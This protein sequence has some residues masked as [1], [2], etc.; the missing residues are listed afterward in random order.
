ML[1]Q[2]NNQ[3]DDREK[4]LFPLNFFVKSFCRVFELPLLRN[5]RKPHKRKSSKIFSAPQFYAV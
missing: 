4:V 1:M 2:R 3:N 5:A